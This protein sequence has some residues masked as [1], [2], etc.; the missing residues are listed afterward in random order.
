MMMSYA[1]TAIDS[2][3]TPQMKSKLLLMQQYFY[4]VFN[5]L[6]SLGYRKV[7]HVHSNE[8]LTRQ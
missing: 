3:A 5:S 6:S 8:M 7:W 4:G 1:G 2:E